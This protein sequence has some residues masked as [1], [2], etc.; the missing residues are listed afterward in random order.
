MEGE[1]GVTRSII[2]ELPSSYI[3][4]DQI[5][6]ESG[7]TSSI[8]D[9]LHSWVIQRGEMDGESGVT[10]C[11]IDELDSFEPVKWKVKVDLLEVSLVNFIFQISNKIKWRGESGVTPSI[12]AEAHSWDIQGEKMEGSSGITVSI[13]DELLS[14]HIEVDQIE[15]GTMVLHEVSLMNF[16]LR[17]SKEMKWKVKAC[18]HSKY[19]RC[20]LFMRYPTRSNG[21]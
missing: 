10:R 13:V 7:V 16:I 21:R 8:I 15:V 2:D 19:H 9:E 14:C 11:I 1:S 6:G 18:C 20:T 3:Q 5:K 12:I 4:R 17:I